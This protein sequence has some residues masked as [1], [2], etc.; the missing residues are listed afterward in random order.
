M[1]NDEHIVRLAAVIQRL[2]SAVN[3]VDEDET[4]LRITDSERKLLMDEA[5]DEIKE[6]RKQ[7]E[8]KTEIGEMS[9]TPAK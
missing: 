2:I 4:G 8:E 5:K 3:K 1:K 6:I 7:Q 9:A